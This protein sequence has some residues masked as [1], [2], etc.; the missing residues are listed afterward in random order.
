MEGVV[1]GL[2][3]NFVL[4]AARPVEFVGVIVKAAAA[5]LQ[6]RTEFANPEKFFGLGTQKFDQTIALRDSWPKMAKAF[7]KISRCLVMARSSARS[8]E[9]S[10]ANSLALLPPFETPRGDP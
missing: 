6:G 5:N 2:G 4:Q 3:K 10:S 7:F 8:S 9:S 1:D